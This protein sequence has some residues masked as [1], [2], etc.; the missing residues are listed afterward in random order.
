MVMRRSMQPLLAACAATSLVALLVRTADAKN[1]TLACDV[2]VVGAGWAGAYLAWRLSADVSGFKDSVHEAGAA[3]VRAVCLFEAYRRPGG[4]TYSV[5]IGDYVVD[6]GAYRFAGDMHLPADLIRALGFLRNCYDPTCKDDDVSGEVPWPYEEPL[7]KIVDFAGRHLGYGSAIDKMLDQ[8]TLAGGVLHFGE[9]L[10]GVERGEGGTWVLNMRSGL[11]AIA[12]LPSLL[13]ARWAALNCSARQFPPHLTEGRT[14]VKVYAV[15]ED[16]WWV[17]KLG[18]MRGTR[19]NLTVPPVA[20][21]YHDGEV[22]CHVGSDPSGADIWLPA[23]DAAS[24]GEAALKRCRGVLQVFYRH[25]QLCPSDAPGCMDYW[26]ALPRASLEDPLTVVGQNTHSDHKL[27]ADTDGILFEVHEKLLRM[28]ELDFQ[29]R[30]ISISTVADIKPPTTLAY[31]VWAHPGTLPPGDRGLLAGPYDVI[32][33]GEA[34]PS[35]CAAA[36]PHVYLAMT[37]GVGRWA[38]VAPGLHVAN[39]D[40]A[41]TPANEWHGPWAEQSLLAAEQIA[42]KGFGLPRPAW[43]NAA[44]YDTHVLSAQKASVVLV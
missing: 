7:S 22:V 40:Y 34:P 14:T 6:A 44:Y 38:E 21:R 23:R 26:S 42:A 31:S 37:Q 25:S 41:M 4:R 20:M 1:A 17:S 15:Y 12:G 11:Q 13:G 5:R 33:Q 3:G 32:F 36:S 19:E 10:V 39:N 9:E 24:G 27:N 29:S 8:V 18:L 28:H 43:L 16:A 35:A 2:S 30:G